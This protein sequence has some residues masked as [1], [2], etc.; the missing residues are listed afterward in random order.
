M[1]IASRGGTR[2]LSSTEGV[3]GTKGVSGFGRFGGEIADE[4]QA[5]AE[6]ACRLHQDAALR[7][8]ARQAGYEILAAKFDQARN[9]ARLLSE[10]EAMRGRIEA[11]R[12]AN[13]TGRMLE[14]HAHRSTKYFSRW[15]ETKNAKAQAAALTSSG[16]SSP[17]YSGAMMGK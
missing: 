6:A 16:R 3:S 12:A 14:H 10:I 5:F 7:A 13:F 4:A 2:G 17:R 11:H 8:R 1:D 9:G 15:I